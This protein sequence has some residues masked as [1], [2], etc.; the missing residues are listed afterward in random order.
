MKLLVAIDFSEVTELILEKVE[1][2]ALKTGA[3]V[4]LIHVVRP[5]PDFIGYE[6]GPDSERNFMAKRFRDKHVKIQEVSE[7]LKKRGIN[8]TPL[9]VQG[10]TVE[11]IIEKAKKLN[12]DMIVSGS[13]GHGRMFY[14]MV[15]STS[16]GLIKKSPI[17]MLIIPAKKN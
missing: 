8:I 1:E 10:P 15:G 7:K 6:V 5:E 11:T 9:L 12:V 13:H 3:K 17:P 2:I 4:W 14:I 16:K